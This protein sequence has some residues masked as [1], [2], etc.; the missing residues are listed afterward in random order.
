MAQ[1]AEVTA[2]GAALSAKNYDVAKEDIDKAMANLET[3]DKPLA[4][5]YKAQVYLSLQGVDKYKASNPYREGAQ[6]L[7]KL[8]EVGPDYKPA[9]VDQLLAYTA[10]KYYNDGAQAY[11]DKKLAKAEEDMK[12]VIKIRDMKRMDKLEPDA[13]KFADTIFADALQI[14]ASSIYFQSKYDEAIPLLTSAKNNPIAR[15]SAIYECL[16]D[17]LQKQKNKTE[18]LAMIEEG[19]KAYPEDILIMND[20]LNYYIAYGSSEEIIKKLEAAA[21]QQP[22]NGEILFNLATSYQAMARPK[23]GNPPANGDELFVKAETVYQK[24]LKIAPDNPVYNYNFGAMYFN[25]AAV[26]NGRMTAITGSTDADQKKYDDLKAGRNALLAKSTPYFENAGR[27][28]SSHE[29]DMKPDDKPTYKNTM[30][31]LMDI[32]SRLQEMDKYAE[33]KKKYDSLN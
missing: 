25:E 2:A 4:L 12:Y 11:N 28:Y 16:I 33:A 20:E 5:L 32:Y 13:Q 15:T 31:A 7:F 24:A 1:D 29:K 6:A 14:L 19:R 21:A 9:T 3:K 8:V 26:V 18:T 23:E 17:A 10:A 22:G 30:K 27:V